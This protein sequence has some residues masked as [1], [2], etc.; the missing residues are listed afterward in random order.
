MPAGQPFTLLCIRAKTVPP[1]RADLHVHSTASDGRYTPAQ[2]VEIAGRSGLA[3]VALTDHDT[4]AGYAAAVEAAPRGLEVIPAVELTA[5]LDGREVHLLGYFVRPDDPP[6]N[7]ALDRLREH[8]SGRF[9]DMVQR[10]RACGVA[11]PERAASPSTTALGR[12]HLAELLVGCGLVGSVREAFNRYLDAGKPAY[13]P[14]KRF[15]FADSIRL[16]RGASGVCSL[17]HP[18]TTLS[19]PAIAALRDM[20]LDAVEAVYPSFKTSRSARLRDYC[21]QLDLLVTG[22]SDCHGPDEPK[23]AVGCRTVTTDELS[24]LRRRA[25]SRMPQVA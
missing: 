16:V 8:R 23:R 11:V 2:V 12:R 20:G 6:L 1:S 25:A 4:L 15:T 19:L 13:V 21:R 9:D 14:T 5:E 17:A 18:P 3:A 24:A 7:S 10:L 22:G